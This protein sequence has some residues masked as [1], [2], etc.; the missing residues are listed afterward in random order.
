MN[1]ILF[2]H[3]DSKGEAFKKTI[4]Q[5][6]NELE[7]Q[8]F[9]T[10][11]TFKARLEQ[12]SN[13]NK[14]IFVLFADSKR[15]LNELTSLIDLMEDRRVIL[16]LPDDSK[17]TVSKAHQFFPRYFTYVNDTYADLCAVITKISNKEKTNT[18]KEGNPDGSS[19]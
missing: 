5:N 6:F 4:K 7:I 19:S 3:Q 18:I 16:I 9:Q 11:N 1:L 2:I 12:V 14:E 10:L 15:C 8:T 13:Y 17:K